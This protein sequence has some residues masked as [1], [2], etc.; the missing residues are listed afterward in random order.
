MDKVSGISEE[1][2]IDF[3]MSLLKPDSSNLRNEGDEVDISTTII[4]KES[5]SNLIKN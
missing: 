1:N 2:A 4:K 5:T 3:R